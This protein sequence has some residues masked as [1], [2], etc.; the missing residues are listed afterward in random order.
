MVY[1][2][3]RSVIP[4]QQF[5]DQ[6]ASFDRVGLVQPR[7]TFIDSENRPFYV[8]YISDDV[9][10]GAVE[11]LRYYNKDTDEYII[12]ANGIWLNPIKIKDADF[13]ISP[14]PF[15]HKELPFWDV[16]FDV[17]G[18]DFFYGKSLPDRLK[19]MQD[20]LNVLTNML[21]D[22]SFLT[23]FKP[24]LTAGTDSIEDDFMRP[25]RRTPI[26]T[27]GLPLKDQ[28]MVLDPGAPTGW[29]QFILEYTRRVM[30]EAS[31]DK[32]SQGVA[33]VGDRVTAEEIKTAAEGV[34]SLLGMFA[35]FVN[36]GIKRKAMLKGANILQFWTDENSPIYKK[37]LG[38]N[39]AE[40]I[41]AAFNSFEIDNTVL[42]NG[43]RGMKIIEMFSPNA[44]LPKRSE[45]KARA[46]ILELENNKPVEVVAVPTQYLRDM[47]FDIELIPDVSIGLNIV[48]NDWSSSM[49]VRTF[50]TSCIDLSL[51]GRD[52]P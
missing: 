4:L 25:G 19:S 27:Q 48:R 10:D 3:W 6:W 49:F 43:K 26:D 24:I 52:L 22:Q 13:E 34:A 20:V 41:N 51:S 11:L 7:S 30:E 15:N 2:F 31:V 44:E 35:R 1:C 46:K 18:V 21:L 36:T 17:F 8:Q 9:P 28:Y 5:R 45:I 42:T 23:I 37:V 14:L 33:G 50:K 32:V 38:P 40:D 29:H 16:K 12:L 39:A 47:K